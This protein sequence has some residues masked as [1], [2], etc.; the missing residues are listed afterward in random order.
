VKAESAMLGYLNAPSPFDD[1][2][3]FDT[4]DKVEVDG[5]WLRILGRESEIINVGGSKVYPAEVEDA[6]LQIEGV[7]DAAVHGEPHPIT[8]QIVAATVV[9]DREESLPAFK[10]RM[11]LALKDKVPSFK[12]PAKVVISTEPVHSARFKRMRKPV[13]ADNSPQRMPAGSDR[14]LSEYCQPGPKLGLKCADKTHGV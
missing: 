6:L 10:L 5:E 11:R 12:I 8:G 7:T 4:G 13:A 1:E 3:Y 14:N 2:G 9:L